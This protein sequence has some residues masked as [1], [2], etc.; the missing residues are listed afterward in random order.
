M[1]RDIAPVRIR[2]IMTPRPRTV[3]PKTSVRTLQH[4]FISYG[5]NAFPVVD[6]AHILL[7][8]VTKLDLLRVVRHGPQ[9]LPPE[10][11]VLWAEHVDDIMRRRVVTLAPDDSVAT[12]VDHMLSSRLRSLLVVESRGRKAVL[13]GMV[14]RGDVLSTLMLESNA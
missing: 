13:I 10:L 12:A 9:R 14:S 1:T 6:E 7:G 8:I 4:L 2:D 11:S 5:F 3:G